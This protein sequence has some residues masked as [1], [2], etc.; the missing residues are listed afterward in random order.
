MIYKS[1]VLIFVVIVYINCIIIIL[2]SGTERRTKTV[3]KLYWKLHIKLK[4]SSELRQA[5]L[6]EFTLCFPRHLWFALH[7]HTIYNPFYQLACA[8]LYNNSRLC[9]CLSLFVTVN[10]GSRG[11]NL[12]GLN[13]DY[14]RL[15]ICRTVHTCGEMC[16]K[17]FCLLAC[18]LERKRNTK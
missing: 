18:C 15:Q 6:I 8:M 11:S 17:P 1:N 4:L 3:S 2:R 16:I 10:K 5:D 13:R 12:A 9:M 14:L 7:L